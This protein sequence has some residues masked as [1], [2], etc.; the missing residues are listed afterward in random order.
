M[1]FVPLALRG[2]VIDG[3]EEMHGCSLWGSGTVAN[4]DRSRQPSELELNVAEMQGTK[5]AEITKKLS[6]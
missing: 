2:S 1:L 3:A 5:F 4:S 6:A